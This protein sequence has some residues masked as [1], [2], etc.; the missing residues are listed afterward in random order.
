MSCKQ[1]ILIYLV[2]CVVLLAL[3]ARHLLGDLR[4]VA[5]HLVATA[6]HFAP[7]LLRAAVALVR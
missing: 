5:E 7:G 2:V 6:L 3:V 1:A 4:F